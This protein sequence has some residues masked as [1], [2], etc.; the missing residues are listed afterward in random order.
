MTRRAAGL[1]LLLGAAT[2]LS[3]AAAP[4][5]SVAFDNLKMDGI[6][7]IQYTPNEL[8]CAGKAMTARFPGLTLVTPSIR[9]QLRQNRVTTAHASGGVTMDLTF[10]GDDGAEMKLHAVGETLDYVAAQETATLLGK[11]V[12]VTLRDAGG[13]MFTGTGAA[14][15]RVQL[16]KGA[17][18]NF[19]AQA[20]EGKVMQ[21][22][23]T[24]PP[25]GA[26]GGAG[27]PPR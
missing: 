6:T 18:V 26:G 7:T 14:Q 24:A 17:F 22:N 10:K 8:V 25:A 20:P 13:G 4:P 3:G 27:A 12:T 5:Q 15:M 9:L 19:E 2:A 11:A 23:Y 16:A 1:T 21:W